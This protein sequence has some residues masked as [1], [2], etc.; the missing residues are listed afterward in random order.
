LAVIRLFGDFSGG[1][2]SEW[3]EFA[4]GQGVEIVSQP[5]GGAGKN[6]AD[7]ALTIGAMD[8]LYEGVAGTF[9]L[10][11]NDRDFVP[12]ALRLRR[13][14]R[15]VL[16]ATEKADSRVEAVCHE[17]LELRREVAPAPKP[18][19]V[20][21]APIVAAY[22][23]VADGK[24]QMPLAV[25]GALLRKHAPAVVPAGAGKVRKALRDSGWFDESGEGNT[26][27][28]VLRRRVA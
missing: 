22:Q 14:G 25:L 12:L 10:A 18:T 27:T 17:V 24:E 3:A 9:V 20:V 28:V 23:K 2:L 19:K 15:R 8:L 13:S 16:L 26:L 11:S 21:V 1:R 5:N 7:I 6:S 4:R